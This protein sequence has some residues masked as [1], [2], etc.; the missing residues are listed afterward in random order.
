VGEVPSQPA[1]RTHPPA[2][3][4]D[5]WG[6][7]EWRWWDGYSWTGYTAGAPG[8]RRPAGS[9]YPLDPSRPVEQS[10][11]GE[12]IQAGWIA[13]G[14][15]VAGVLLSGIVG[16]AWGAAG[17]SSHSAVLLALGE[18]GLWVGLGGSCLLASRLRGTGRLSADFG[19]RTAGPIDIGLG[20]GAAIAGMVVVAVLSSVFRAIG[21]QY[22]GSNTNQFSGY[23]G[24]WPL[25]L[26]ALV[27][28]VG[29]PVV[30][31]LFFRGLVQGT[32]MRR[33]GPRL[34]IPGQAAL[35]GLGH[36]DPSQHAATVSIVVA[37]GAFGVIQGFV[38]Y[39]TGRLAP[40]IL[41]HSL[42]NLVALIGIVAG[43]G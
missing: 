42:F 4:P 34:A 1:E 9:P 22:L 6:V 31:E 17:G 35:F 2:W 39:R 30:E 21:P 37:I 24:A 38:R 18:V 15:I 13:I 10:P 43:T 14:G 28:C 19:L 16:A 27:L 25:L 33:Y 23:T 3:Y 40:T 20:V 26:V 36:A 32:L 11:R 5:P 12:G 41:S 7:A 29:A 8:P